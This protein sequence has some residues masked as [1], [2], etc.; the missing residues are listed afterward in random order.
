MLSAREKWNMGGLSQ[1]ARTDI[2]F[3]T[4]PPLMQISSGYS[5]IAQDRIYVFH[6][7]QYYK[8]YLKMWKGSICFFIP[9]IWDN[10]SVDLFPSFCHSFSPDLL[11]NA[12]PS[13]TNTLRNKELHA[14]RNKLRI[15]KMFSNVNTP[16]FRVHQSRLCKQTKAIFCI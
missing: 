7:A 16:L 5:L 15:K 13:N 2:Y 1:V 4:E 6:L 11:R 12:Y 8:K 10:T 14:T 9:Y 3:S